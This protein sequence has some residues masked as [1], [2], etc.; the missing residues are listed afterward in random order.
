MF[1]SGFSGGQPR[2]G[3]ERQQPGALIG[4]GDSQRGDG[5]A[6]CAPCALRREQ[7]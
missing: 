2:V 1:A 5:L 6:P 7:M 4:W 3:V